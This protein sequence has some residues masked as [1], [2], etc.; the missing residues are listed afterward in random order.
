M[1]ESL[2]FLDHEPGTCRIAALRNLM[3]VY[4]TSRATESAVNRLAAVTE[5]V[6][7]RY[8]AGLSAV[9]VIASTAGLPTPEARAGFIKIMREK[10]AQLACV[11]VV[12]GGTGFWAS[13]MRS[14]V[15][16]LRFMSP[17]SFDLRLHGA[18]SEVMMWLPKQHTKLTG[19]TLDARQLE[20]ILES[21]P[22]WS[23]ED[24]QDL[25]SSGAR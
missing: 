8:P 15:T 1:G 25:F 14:F 23:T 10:A 11:A 4:W 22:T 20:R 13:A 2:E 21:V 7:E 12:V 24:A 17:R 16:G 6:L 3:I 5:R 19:V 18:P 9:H